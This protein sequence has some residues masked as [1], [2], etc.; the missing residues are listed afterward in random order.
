MT[1]Y[2][3]IAD[4]RNPDAPPI[5]VDHLRRHAEAAARS[6]G[7]TRQIHGRGTFQPRIEAARASLDNLYAQLDQLPPPDYSKIV[8][9]DPILELREHPRLLRAVILEAWSLRRKISPLPRVLTR[10][11]KVAGNPADPTG[12]TPR[13]AAVASCFFDATEGIWNPDAF[14]VY[15]EQLQL[16]DPLDLEEIWSISTFLKLHLLE[17]IISQANSLLESPNTDIKIRAQLSGRIRTLRETGFADWV[18]LLE[19]LIVFDKTL[20]QDPAKSYVQ[21]DFETRESYRKH[22]ARYARYSECSESQVAATALELARESQKLPIT[23]P[24]LYLRRSHIGY[25]L[26]DKG[27]PQLASRI[28]HRPPFIDRLRTLIR[29]NADDFYIGGIEIVSVLLM[30]AVIVP[31]AAWYS[32]IA[33]LAAGLLLLLLPA[34][35]GAIDL[36]NNI[37]TALFK[38]QPLPKLDFSSGI[39][40]EFTTLVAIP[41][42]LMNEK[43][44][45]ELVED[46]EVRFLANPDPNLHFGLLTDLPDSVTRPR[47][48]DSDPLVDLAVNLIDELNQR[49]A[50]GRHGSFFL[51]HRHRIFNARQGVWMGWERK[52]GKLLDLNK[53]LQND[54]DAFPVK[55]G[56]LDVLHRVKYIIT[57]DSDTQLPRGTAAALVGAITHPLNRAI[58]DPKLRTV[59]EGYGLLQPR[60]GVSV[61]SASRSRLAAI[62]SGQTGFD[63]YARAVSDAYQDLYG[64]GIFTGKGIYE[65]AT[66]HSVLDRRFPRNSLLSH[67]LIEGSYA[68]VG[69]A[70]DIEVIDDYPSHY[71]AYTRR[72]HRWVR[73]DWQIAQWMFSKVPDE[74]GRHV[75]NPISTIARWRILDNLRRSLVEPFTFI[76]L[77]AGWL[78]LPGG[79]LYWT[80]ATLL[81]FFLPNLVQLVFSLG[82]AVGSDQ[83]GAVG[84]A[85][86]GFFQAIGVSLLTLAFL[87][88]Q[89]LLS[90]DAIVRSLVR[91]FITGQRL[92]EWETAAEAEANAK[93]KKKTPVDTYLS[94][95]PLIA[96]GLAC[97]I[98]YFNWGALH[99]AVPVLVLWG[100][101]GTVTS[102][103]NAPPRE[104]H[105]SIK[106]GD[107][108]FLRQ[109]ALRIWRFYAEFGSEQHNYLI[110][111][112]VEEEGLFEAPRVST[113][114]I[115]MLLNARQAAADFG[116]ITASE[117]VELTQ[118]T[119]VSIHKLEKLNG[120]AY[121]WY[122]TLTLAPLK[123]ITISSVDNGN[124]A[125]SLYTLRA[126]A[127]AMLKLPLLR[128][129]VF[130]GLR[131]HWQLMLLQKGIPEQIAKHPLPKPDA[132]NDDWVAWCLGAELLDGF[133]THAEL[134]GE[135]AW[136]LREAH[137]RI[138]AINRL[139][140][141]Y[142]PW[143]LP[144]FAPLRAI[145]Q[146]G[147]TLETPIALDRAPEFATQLES[148]LDRMWATST[149]QAKAVLS[150]QLRALLPDAIARLKTLNAALHKI[151]EDAFEL[152]DQMDFGFLLEKSRLLLSIGYEVDTRKLHTATYDML[153]SEARI[154]TFLAVAKGDIPQQS[155]FKLSR[156]HTIAYNRPVL[157]SWTG[158]MFEYLMPSLWM[159]S[160]PD[161]LVS[162]T[163]NAAVL[164]QRDFG[165]KHGIPWGISESGYAEKTPDGHYHYQAFG[166]PA[167]ALKWDA[168]AGPVVS[169]YSSFLA[170]GTDAPEAVK[171]LR[172]MAKAGWVG[173]YGFYE[174]AD[175]SQSRSE[176][177]LV[178]EWMAHHQGMSLLAIL[179]LLHDNIVQT[180]FHS[181]PQLQATELLLHEKPIREAALRAEY[182][183]FAPKTRK[184][185]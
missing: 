56:N 32:V 69:L 170:L 53:Y 164:I 47:E 18:P 8:L 91:R 85:F 136:W 12:E 17:Q 162:R 61:S 143:M 50:H 52:R 75:P 1:E 63:I 31:L 19:S 76:L 104:Q 163:L 155:W 144:E 150:E 102:W 153:A 124:L 29:N 97:I 112:N 45:R 148:R 42:L 145:P 36:F 15:I 127:M 79:P 184:T 115:G 86:S 95:M 11:G 107:E 82:H 5:S 176:A 158:T 81:I 178:R 34:T 128:P 181:N 9:P 108:T 23:D 131:T 92:L 129:Q 175:Y 118:R 147:F 146:L 72:K 100:F 83:E 80:A 122:D 27:L 10:T 96:I 73:G 2:I 88:H 139:V 60:V 119:L 109:Q 3:Q 64:E 101:A 78:G 28:G 165:R 24:R 151:A 43:Q 13:N 140:R 51:L 130:S 40:A 90:L 98:W 169:P 110:P 37:V 152:A 126:G 185:A 174:A 132:S 55:T 142:R 74:S 20:R 171:N 125:A 41:T 111:D 123:P 71:S 154:A 156:T 182:K 179:N 166:I 168:T 38:A 70:T 137:D 134:T 180:W 58:I 4:E 6:W 33:E 121:N 114:N 157:L 173:A 89:T 161:T 21:M 46:L 159:R 103:L 106:P 14:R 135:A 117:F 94:A 116:F 66:F 48:N 30:A 22:V 160:Y 16:D 93:A 113:T 133:S 59:T 172:R 77:V 25:Y 62:Y 44:L 67:D 120:H 141:E 39:P 149:D 105:A 7:V 138:A 84:E 35:Q 99:I 65:V 167:T 177:R 57:L 26:V 68:R 54:Y 87:P 183:Q 49:Y